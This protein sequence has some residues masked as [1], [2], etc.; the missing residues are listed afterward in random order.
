MTD[1]STTEG[2]A[3]I[4]IMRENAVENLR[5]MSHD[6]LKAEHAAML[7]D[8]G[9][10]Q[11][12]GKS[13]TEYLATL[14]ERMSATKPGGNPGQIEVKG[15]DGKPAKP[16]SLED[17]REVERVGREAELMSAE[18]QAR[19]DAAAEPK[20]V[21]DFVQFESGAA[22]QVLLNHAVSPQTANYL[23]QQIDE[24]K[25]WSDD[26]YH[27]RADKAIELVAKRPD[28]AAI[29]RDADAFVDEIEKA[30]PSHPLYK[31][32]VLALAY[33]NGLVELARLHRQQKRGGAA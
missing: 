22:R 16:Q 24:Y 10:H 1:N 31:P 30:G 6:Q 17:A 23:A 28:G 29:L 2:G 19:W 20:H 4:P 7:G 13:K 33:A 8:K 5:N 27:S 26:E 25:T 32:T 14:S 3:S 18:E 21:N 11:R 12:V 15:E 9:F